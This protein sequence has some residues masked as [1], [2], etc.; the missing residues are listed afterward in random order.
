MRSDIRPRRADYGAPLRSKLMHAALLGLLMFV[1][2]TL[3]TRLAPTI[4][5]WWVVVAVAVV[6]HAGLAL[7]ALAALAKWVL[8]VNRFRDRDRMLD[9][10]TWRGDERV[11]DVGCGEGILTIAAAK[12]IPNGHVVG[13][14]DWRPIHGRRQL[15]PETARRNA[16]VENVA[17]RVTIQ[18]ADGTDLPFAGDSFDVVMASFAIHHVGDQSQRAAALAEM[19]RVLRPGGAVAIVDTL[20]TEEMVHVLTELGLEGVSRTSRTFPRFLFRWVRGRKPASAATLVR[21]PHDQG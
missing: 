16:E 17:E 21:C 3:V 19:V 9:S 4:S 13:I 20:F 2:G 10:I 5:L 18:D 6:T 12:R 15:G 7:V 11:L 14:D 8:S 1:G